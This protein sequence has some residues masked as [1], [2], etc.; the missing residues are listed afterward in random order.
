[1][2]RGELLAAL[3]NADAAA[4]AGDQEAAADA[5]K[6][7]SMLKTM[8]AEQAPAPK[9]APAMALDP[10]H[11][12]KPE[13][14]A[15][16]QAI[17]PK[18]NLPMSPLGP[19]NEKFAPPSPGPQGD[20]LAPLNP[21][22]AAA[23][24]DAQ[25]RARGL[26]PY[27]NASTG[28]TYWRPDPAKQV[29]DANAQFKAREVAKATGAKAQ[30]ELDAYR[31]SR[32][33][34]VNQLS[35]AIR[36]GFAATENAAFD[37]VD[38]L[39]FKIDPN[40]EL[41]RGISQNI[42]PA[43]EKIGQT[44]G[45][46]IEGPSGRFGGMAGPA[47]GSMT[48]GLSE[49]GATMARDPQDASTQIVDALEPT[50]Q[51]ARG[52]NMTGDALSAAIAGDM[53]TAGSKFAQ[54][55]PDL[56]AGV[57]GVLPFGSVT[58]TALRKAATAPARET[59]EQLARIPAMPAT[60]P[61]PML[62]P[63]RV[64]GTAA[65][66]GP[67]PAGPTAP[68]SAVPARSRAEQRADDIF[69]RKLEADGLTV[70][71]LRKIQAR[72]ARRGDS[73]VYETS[74]EIAALTDKSSG[75]NL[76]GL[77]MAGGAAPGPLQEA[78][79]GIVNENTKKL[80]NR[81][82]RGATRATG[83]NADNAV[84]TLDELETRLRTEASPAYDT[85]Y[86]TPV[87]PQVF[88]NEILPVLN[89]PSGQK[90]LQAARN[91]LAS[92]SADLQ[93]R[94]ARGASERATM[95]AKR[96]EA[97][98]KSI[99]DFM[100]SLAPQTEAAADLATPKPIAIPTTMA[101]D[102]TKRAFDDVIA[103]AGFGSD[104]ARIVGGTKRNFADSVSQATDG[105]YGNALGVFEDVK[106]LE[107]AFDTGL[108]A[109]SQPTWELERAMSKG[110]AGSPWTAGE[111]EALAMGVARNIEDLIEANNQS[112]L[113][114]LLKDK[115]LKNMATA[116]GSQKAADMFEETIRRLGANREWG[117]RVA[118]G[119]DT[120]MRQAAIRDAGMEGE[121]AVTRVLDRIETSGNQFSLPGLVNDVAVKPVAKVAKDF[122][123]QMRY[124]GVYDEEVNRA[125]I[126][127]V[128]TPMTKGNLDEVIRRVEQRLA[129][130][131]RRPA[132]ATPA[133]LPAPARGGRGNPPG[134]TSSAAPAVTGAVA[135]GIVG[136]LAPAD[137]ED[138]QFINAM[139]GAGIGGLGVGGAAKLMD[140]G[141]KPLPPRGAGGKAQTAWKRDPATV[142]LGTQDYLAY[143]N[144][145]YPPA[146][147]NQ[148]P[149]YF[150]AANTLK[151]AGGDRQA[152][153][154][155]LADYAAS[156]RKN[157]AKPEV[158]ENADRATK[159]VADVD[160]MF[161]N[162]DAFNAR[163]R[164][165]I[166]AGGEAA[167]APA[168]GAADAL[169]G[170]RRPRS[171]PPGVKPPPV[172]NGVT[173][174][175]AGGVTGS[176]IGT[177]GAGEADAQTT[178]TAQKIA[179]N[180]AQLED[181]LGQIAGFEND[182]KIFST[183][184]NKEIQA[185][186]DREGFDLGPTGIDGDIGTNTT[187]A[188]RGR[189]TE[190]NQNLTAARNRLKEL[191]AQAQELKEQA[192]FEKT[193]PTDDQQ[194]FRDYAPLLGGV[195]GALAGKGARLGGSAYSKVSAKKTIKELDKLLNNAP[196]LPPKTPAQ[197]AAVKAE[198]DRRASSLNEFW[199][200]G[201]SDKP[202]GVKQRLG[203]EPTKGVPFESKG[204]G[205]W[206]PRAPRRVMSPSDLFPDRFI[207]RNV[208][209][210][211]VLLGGAGA[212]EAYLADQNA[213][214]VKVKLDEAYKVA[215]DDPTEKNLARV[216]ELEDQY[217]QSKAWAMLGT[218]L[219]VGTGIGVFT[220]KYAS[221]RGNVQMAEEELAILRRAIADLNKPA[222]T[223]TR[224]VKQAP[225]P[226]PLPP[227]PQA[228]LPAPASPPIQPLP[229]LRPRRTQ[230]PPKP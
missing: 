94:A 174:M 33:E 140:K 58:T 169:P 27:T 227:A 128:G 80:P 156:L 12:V 103:D 170:E 29:A 64:A 89:T 85:A 104:T 167:V 126:P 180:K 38:R 62:P 39:L 75:A 142:G 163:M 160:P 146:T 154:A 199:R 13:A 148:T 34:F 4:S 173:N 100:A 69:I 172:R 32:P 189:K 44:I 222:A 65:A 168:R 145:K 166:T 99:D 136:G 217:A 229:P 108:K 51:L 76:R 204:G 70:E 181:M 205:E 77:Q 203:M 191:E 46:I 19:G 14:R 195:V 90:A 15:Q 84:A 81:L 28:E 196:I 114:K 31:N 208:G 149:P 218:G 202:R 55:A 8:P 98:V 86:A 82:S 123:R 223:S 23:N 59:A 95:E 21:Q 230:K 87:N 150:I 127:L 54:A 211:D 124:P 207:G 178:E 1:M 79:V 206:K 225:A 93:G 5:R 107:D 92:I 153:A 141:G 35:D 45:N 193:R 41:S 171:G 219:A 221:K 18:R 220:S 186:L 138:E 215:K 110:R 40:K 135:G 144:A 183:G 120:A 102:Y 119:S 139:F 116:L 209:P 213:Q 6:L 57:V 158:I 134:T 66:G 17:Q 42:T 106:R 117:R 9:P 3:K 83:Q 26:V 25:Q 109:L 118:G 182:L 53:G 162:D 216:Q 74:G 24:V 214:R 88:A 187:A 20:P 157:N 226:I 73:G 111:V 133:A 36:G 2:N 68:P 185:Q 161:F 50:H 147:P 10:L 159:A 47:I 11:M 198:I 176:A 192:A 115:A 49:L 143:I 152:A 56:A 190:I 101:L 122:Y 97:A 125:L 22:A 129:E 212:T 60:G 197:R 179:D 200:K 210:T 188:I 113:T 132:A 61:V 184:T 177:F 105:Q 155:E 30:A 96:A 228:L 151:R 91:N 63:R 16:V 72:L 175:V 112:A 130:K 165:E 121:D 71:D 48:G 37:N 164:S 137:S 224:A 43:A 78:L 7:A 131:G 194:A 52:S 201:G 67:P